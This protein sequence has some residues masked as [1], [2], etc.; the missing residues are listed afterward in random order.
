MALLTR[1]HGCS[2]LRVLTFSRLA[3]A[4]HTCARL[5]AERFGKYKTTLLPGL[6]IVVPFVD[7][8]RKISWRFVQTEYRTNTAKVVVVKTDRVDVRE[9]VLDFAPQHII[10]KDTVSLRINALVF[11]RIVDPRL[12]VY[13]IQDLPDAIELLTQSSLRQIC[14]RMS[15][16]DTFSSR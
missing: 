7:V 11:F 3:P 9:H 12:A 10:T 4:C 15:L 1:A 16:D 14:A 5:P 13:N 2:F 6:H 8:P